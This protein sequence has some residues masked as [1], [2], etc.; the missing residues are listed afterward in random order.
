VSARTRPIRWGM[1]GCGDVTER[2]SG[3]AYRLADGSELAGVF[4]RRPAQAKDY[5]R[6]HGVPRI[7]QT[8]DALIHDPD[9]DA[10]YIATPPSSH[11]SY[12]LTTAAAGKPCC[13]EKPMAL[14][15]A[16]ANQM[17]SA[18]DAAGQPLFVAYYRGCLPRFETIRHWLEAG[19]IGN[20][21]QIHW[22]LT[23]PV[24]PL[25]IQEN[26]P[27]RVTPGEAPGG[28]F[29]DLAGHGLDLFDH[30]L[31]PIR[32]VE[33]RT[34]NLAGQHPVPDTFSACWQHENGV[35]GTGFWNF[36]GFDR[37]DRLDITGD[38]GRITTAV[39]EDEPVRLETA[40]G[41]ESHDIAHP[42]PVQ[43]PHV[44]AMIRHLKGGAPH[45]SLAASAVRTARVCDRI[46]AGDRAG[47]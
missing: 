35:T 30:W 15:E 33:G 8:A 17:K 36:A 23:R 11:A 18:F 28:Y 19:R 45:P 6:R 21:R 4:T 24:D 44:E 38:K 46:L 22:A 13:V 5:A 3:P 41:V 7:F 20:V 10:V 9:I 12:A 2:K 40:N 32:S 47:K 39:F 34:A 37:T 27:W 29:D 16:E 43:L 14:S 26:R 31:R 1:I 25:N 42:D